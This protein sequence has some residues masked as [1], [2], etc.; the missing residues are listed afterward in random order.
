MPL[1]RL[2]PRNLNPLLHPLCLT[3]L[4]YLCPHPLFLTPSASPL[5]G[6]SASPSASLLCLT[7]LACFCLTP[8]PHPL[9]AP[10]PHLL[11][12]PS[13]CQASSLLSHLPRLYLPLRRCH[14]IVMQQLNLPHST[15][16]VRQ[17][18][19]SQPFL[20]TNITHSSTHLASL[21]PPCPPTSPH[22]PLPA[23]RRHVTLLSPPLP[24]LPAPITSL[25][26]SCP[27]SSPTPVLRPREPKGLCVEIG[28]GV[29]RN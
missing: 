24:S 8:L 4:A 9:A 22:P 7:P 18:H 10:L 29:E 14:P 5:S 2:S 3:P 28:R 15:L 12:Q 25:S 16:L 17:H 23:R 20:S 19:P 13:A 21:P 11:P 6:S 26:P 1:P 27:P